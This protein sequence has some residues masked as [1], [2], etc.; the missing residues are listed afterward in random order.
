MRMT[1]QLTP[2]EETKMH[3]KFWSEHLKGRNQLGDLDV[4]SRMTNKV[5]PG[6]L[7][8]YSD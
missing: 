8:E 2:F 3:I 7:S 4:H 5:K 6:Y 1:D